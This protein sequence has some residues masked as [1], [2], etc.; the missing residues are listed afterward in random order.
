VLAARDALPIAERAA[1]S[2]AITAR[3]LWLPAYR[4]ADCVSAYMSIGS[5]FDT[6][7]FVADILASGKRLLLPRVDRAQRALV[8]H[9]V[10]DPAR[11]L[12][13]GTWG[14]RE[15]D[16]ARCPAIE[17]RAADFVLVPG[18]AFTRAGDRLGY[19]GGFYD[20][21][22]AKL[23]AAARK[24]AAGFSLQVLDS[25]PTGPRDV[26]VDAVVTEEGEWKVIE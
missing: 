1:L 18:V 16:P 11:D 8:F 14:I 25:L 6:A 3:L 12:V 22:L 21:Q 5:E 20:G 19:G 10:D 26:K 9:F 24:V 4:N 7:A 15:P 17:F 2:A 13:P 23:P